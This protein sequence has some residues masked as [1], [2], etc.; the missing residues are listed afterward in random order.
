MQAS[1][2]TSGTREGYSMIILKR[3]DLDLASLSD[4]DP[5]ELDR[6]VALV[7]K[8]QRRE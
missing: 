8:S 6:F 5:G 3:D 4:V 2:P 1:L 7:K